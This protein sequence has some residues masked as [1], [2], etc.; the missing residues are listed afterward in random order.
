MTNKLII[1]GWLDI[2]DKKVMDG[3]YVLRNPWIVGVPAMHINGIHLGET[4]DYNEVGKYDIRTWSKT[5]NKRNPNVWVDDT[6][7]NKYNLYY[8][9]RLREL[10]VPTN[11]Y[12][13]IYIGK[14]SPFSVT[15]RGDSRVRINPKGIYY[16]VVNKNGKL[17]KWK[18][19]LLSMVL[20][21]PEVLIEYIMNNDGNEI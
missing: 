4:F 10:D 18:D 12:Y 6:I 8:R 2:D 5:R 21:S 9:I 7:I 1:K 15:C 3:K 16:V 11:S 20:Y 17:V 13:Q 14:D 19:E